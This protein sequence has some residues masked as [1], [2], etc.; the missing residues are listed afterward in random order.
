MALIEASSMRWQ[1]SV[2]N[3]WSRQFQLPL[4]GRL[5]FLTVLLLAGQSAA[6]GKNN[7]AQL[8]RST[9]SFELYREYM[10]VVRGS[11]GPLKGLS[12]LLDTGATPSVVDA[13]V[14]AKLHLVVTPTSIAVLN[15]NVPGGTATLPSLQIGSTYSENLPVLVQDLSFLQKALPIRIDGIVGLDVFGQSSFVIDY[16]SR[17]IRF[18]PTPS[19]PGSIPL[20]LKEGLAI[21][22]ATVNRAPVHLLLDT[23]A[24]SLILFEDTPELPAKSGS[25][26]PSA[27]TIGDFERDRTRSI[28]L[29]LGTM[30][31]GH[32]SA[33]IVRNHKDAGHDFDGLISPAALGISRIAVDLDQG[34][35]SFTRNP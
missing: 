28:N 25:S 27:K 33:F 4:I 30:E 14:A 24:S 3:F 35:L 18:G 10:V 21:I 22:D 26:R 8:M 12:F 34:R 6:Y 19:M 17:E 1:S 16:P 20:Q 15:G 5:A 29:R 11:A 9:T 31:F 13:K 23:G 32:E 7:A 2:R